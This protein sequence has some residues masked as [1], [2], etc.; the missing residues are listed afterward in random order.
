MELHNQ[1]EL[2]Q[3]VSNLLSAQI[4]RLK[5]VMIILVSATL[6]LAIILV[7]IPADTPNDRWIK[8]G[9]IAFF[10]GLAL[11]SLIHIRSELKKYDPEHSAIIHAIQNRNQ[12]HFFTWI[13]P[14]TLIRNHVAS[15]FIIF[16]SAR[17][18]R[19]RL[20]LTKEA[21]FELIR[22]VQLLIG[23]VTYGYSD[24]AKKRY[25]EDPKSLLKAGK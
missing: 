24:E 13:Y 14:H 4:K 21:D 10:C 5:T 20:L 15:Y 17:K 2:V 7:F 9:M 1:Y 8:L 6:F 12:E 18:K 16:E 22:S 25:R 3:L 23:N 19:Y 11:L